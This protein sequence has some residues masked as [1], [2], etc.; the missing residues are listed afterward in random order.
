MSASRR[1]LLS[2]FESSPF[3]VF[4]KVGGETGSFTR[5][6]RRSVRM[7]YSFLGK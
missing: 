1:F 2:L 7:S 3:K 4:S 5:M 6:A